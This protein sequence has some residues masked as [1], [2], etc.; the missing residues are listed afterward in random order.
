MKHISSQMS[1]KDKINLMSLIIFVGFCFAMYFSFIVY[2]HYLDHNYWSK[3]SI[4]FYPDD[5]FNDFKHALLNPN[6][7][8]LEPYELSGRSMINAYFPFTYIF[9]CPITLLTE[10]Q[11][12]ALFFITFTSGMIFANYHFLKTKDDN[13]VDLIRNVFIF[14]LLT[15]PFLLTIDRA[16]IEG[17]IFLL[18]VGF[19]ISYAQK[20]YERAA[21]IIG[22]A[23]S[24]KFYPGMLAFLFLKDKKYKEFLLFVG[25]SAFLTIISLLAFKGGFVENIQG[26]AKNI[27]I[28]ELTFAIGLKEGA[29]SVSHLL[30]M[31]NEQ[32]ASQADM[33]GTHAYNAGVRYSSSLFGL[34][35]L[36]FL[37]LR[38]ENTVSTNSLL[39]CY[40]IL[41]LIVGT[42]LFF[43]MLKYEEEKWKI[44][45]LIVSYFTLFIYTSFAYKLLAFFVPIWLFINCDKKS[46]YDFAYCVLLALLM[47]PKHYLLSVQ[48]QPFDYAVIINP[49]LMIVICTLII[50]ENFRKNA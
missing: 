13:N 4:L 15:Y 8:A 42:L 31:A 30:S 26:L 43:Y 10:H 2:D 1:K 25:F 12:L 48:K 23:A 14:S 44:T 20:K 49:V 38:L 50:K 29:T 22:I 47:I 6:I 16:N 18:Y 32:I 21:I 11:G 17:W 24:I 28:S 36:L 45:M 41:S 40:K 7:I 46:K 9:F 33:Y 5:R 34:I 35:K 27:H 3:V 39:A 37:D 19:L